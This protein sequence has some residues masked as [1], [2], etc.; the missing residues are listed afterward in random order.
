MATGFFNV[1]VAK[2]EPINS[3]APGT[4]ERESL[5]A[6]IAEARSKQVD[7]P[8]FINGKE[9]RTDKKVPL[10]PPHDHQH[11]LGHFSEGD[12]SH[13]KESIDAALAA[14]AAWA[15][16]SWENRASIFLKAA[17]LIAGP[18]RDKINAATML[19]QSKNAFQ[20]EID[21]A[22]EIVDFLRFNVQYMT[23]IYKQQPASSEGIWNRVE[24]RP[25]EGFVF[26]LTPFNFTAIAGNLPTAPAMMG[27]TVVW[28]PAYTQIYSAHVL[29]EVFNEA[30]VPPGV[31]NLFYVDGPTAGDII[32]QHPDFA[33]IHFTGS[34]AVFQHIW[35]TIGE[36]IYKYKSYPRIVGE[37]GGKD[38]IIAHKSA[39]AKQ[40]ATAITRGAFE[41]Q[42][43]KCSAASRAYIPSN[44]WE[45]V[46]KYVQEDLKTFKMGGT[47]DFS[48]FINAVIDE[49]AF[50]RI[51]KYIDDA[52]ASD[53][54]E[55]IAG[56]GHD[57]SK[58]YFVEPTVLLTTDPKYTTMCEEIFGPVITIYVYEPEEFEA[59]LK[60]VDETSPYALTGAVF[61]QDR[62][63]L[64][65]AV[66]A[67][68]QS[69]GNFY[70]NDKPTGAVV[71][72]Q[73][74]G[75]ARGSGTNDKAGSMINLLRWV[76]PRLIK[77][78]FVSPTDY[79]YPFLGE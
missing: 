39:Y 27:N 40:V 66:K 15:N 71:G 17:E 67:L 48:N 6:A 55:V 46:K 8:M 25:L 26:A 28:K 24:Q 49:K 34:T 54:V 77:E 16:M 2:N 38:F 7:I 9:V 12:A 61:S 76:S 41:F 31:I 70:L 75:G 19:G 60:L 33:G 1:P 63:A 59:T 51:A 56:G 68:E 58:G 22:C 69:A 14:K 72:Q 57:K 30:G 10:S 79:R 29:M 62:Y 11:I 32:F 13:V 78:T 64:E 73:P 52:K 23:E 74:F 20:A 44:I 35:K 37:T 65:V 36:N 50:D 18:Y 45:D 53:K 5:Q 42:G 21:S 43:Q 3:Y 4:K 47:E